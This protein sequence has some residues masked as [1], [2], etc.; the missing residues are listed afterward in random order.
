MK[1]ADYLKNRQP[2]AYRSFSNS[3]SL[4]KVSHAYLLSG[5]KGIPLLGCVTFFA[6]SLVC[7]NPNPLACEDCLTCRRIEH[8]TYSDYLL[9]DGGSGQ[10]K[11]GEVQDLVADFSKTPIES[12]GKMIYV[13]NLVENMNT[14]A[15]NSLLK[16]L[17]EPP[18]GTYAFLT[19]EN[20]SKVL[21]TILSRCEKLRFVLYPT[22]E[23]EAK[24][25]KLGAEKEDAELLSHFVNDECLL[26]EEA[27]KEKYKTYKQLLK[28]T[29]TAIGESDDDMF[30][31]F[32]HEV[33]KTLTSKKDDEPS[34]SNMRYYLDMLI[35]VLKDAIKSQSGQ[36]VSL[37]SFKKD[38]DRA[39][40]ERRNLDK[41][42]AETLKVRGSVVVSTNVPLSMAHIASVIAKE[43]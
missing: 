27:E 37:P 38:I 40:N 1:F 15:V 4:G 3:L 8:G 25:I 20:E 22:D 39:F 41:A 28:D 16:F 5:E 29:I 11:K 13:I 30:Y 12:K 18:A 43:E 36:K 33:T 7:D 24:S 35:L 42:L 10:I 23:V 31:F 26:L 34:Y 9:I 19:T 6:K 32:E 2:I 14:Q 17:E 21:P